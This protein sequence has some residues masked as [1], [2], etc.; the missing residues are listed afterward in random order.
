MQKEILPPN[1][2]RL[3]EGLRDTGYDFNTALA[4]VID[5]SVDAGASHIA[6]RIDMDAEGDIVI[7]VADNGCGMNR[8]ALLNGMT[9]GAAG[10]PDP[11][12]LGKFGLGL[13]TA[14]TAFC[15][16]LSVISRDSGTAKPLKAIWDLDHVEKVG[17]WELLLDAPRK[18]AGASERRRFRAL[19]D[20]RRC[21]RRSTAC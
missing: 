12:R 7:S 4:D 1:P 6:V 17:N 21:G 2:S 14:S 13:K 20:R 10:H 8:D 18:G 16:K 15:R 9:Y 11:R 19:G 3:I 5:N